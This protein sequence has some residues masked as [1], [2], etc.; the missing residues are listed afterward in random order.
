MDRQG[1]WAPYLYTNK[2]PMSAEEHPVTSVLP[3]RFIMEVG[4][5]FAGDGGAPDM[6]PRHG[7]FRRHS[8]MVN[9]ALRMSYRPDEI[10]RPYCVLRRQVLE[11]VGWLT[12]K[13][14][15]FTE[16]QLAV[17]KQELVDLVG[18]ATAMVQDEAVVAA[19]AKFEYPLLCEIRSQI[20]CRPLVWKVWCK[21]NVLDPLYPF[22]RANLSHLGGA[23]GFNE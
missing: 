4:P 15:G 16:D 3:V 6:V 13:G 17:M 2:Q 14:F 20:D 8:I 19:D 12:F 5:K 9:M 22:L 21:E 23:R 18:H 7:T 10:P 11:L 1:E